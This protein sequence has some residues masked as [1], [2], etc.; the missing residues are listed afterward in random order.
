MSQQVHITWSPTL[1]LHYKQRQSL[2]S[3]F[4]CT[5]STS[6][7]ISN[8]WLSSSANKNGLFITWC[9]L[10]PFKNRVLAFKQNC[11]NEMFY[12]QHLFSLPNGFMTALKFRLVLVTALTS[13]LPCLHVSWIKIHYFEIMKLL[14]W[15]S[16][17]QIFF[18][19]MFSFIKAVLIIYYSNMPNTAALVNIFKQI[20]M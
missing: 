14:T 4:W 6:T 8:S 7:L 19:N 9:F 2:P 11:C 3:E 20:K 18:F 10:S 5:L 16:E 13:H 17:E 1:P 12:T 15:K